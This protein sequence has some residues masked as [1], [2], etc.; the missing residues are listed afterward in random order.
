MLKRN[1]WVF[2]IRLILLEKQ[3]WI[4]LY[5]ANQNTGE[6]TLYDY[7]FLDSQSNRLLIQSDITAEPSTS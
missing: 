5:R 6:A 4:R 7:I 3:K 1:F 2:H